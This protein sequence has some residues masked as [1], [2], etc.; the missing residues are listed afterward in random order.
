VFT[1]HRFSGYADALAEIVAK[2]AVIE[3]EDRA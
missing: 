1:C 2:T 3:V